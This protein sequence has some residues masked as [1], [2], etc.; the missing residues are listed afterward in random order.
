MLQ[1]RNL[2]QIL[3]QGNEIGGQGWGCIVAK[4]KTNQGVFFKEQ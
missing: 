1:N 4:T 3:L 2:L